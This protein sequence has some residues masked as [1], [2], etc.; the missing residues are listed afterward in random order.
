MPAEFQK[1][2]DLTLSNF[3]NTYAY[4][5]D[6]VIVTKGS[7]DIHKQKH[8]TIL[9]KLDGENLAI[10][11]EK[12]KF[13]CKQVEWLGYI[14]NSEGTTPLI[15]KTEANEKLS[16][17]KLFKQLK[18]FMG[19]I[20]H[21][22]KYIPNSAQAVAALRPLLK[23]TLENSTLNWKLE[24][25]TAFENIKKLVS[26]II[27]NKHFNQHLET[28][29]VTDASTSGLGASLKQYSPK[30]WVANAYASRFLNS[31][32]EKYS[33]NE[34]ESLGVVWAICTENISPSSQTTKL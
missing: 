33:V 17:P 23:N 28:R 29:I 9:E 12:C 13:A 30:S 19:S 25:N 8:Q 4:L 16:P 34:L 1:A 15:R 5:D 11:L 21:L 10:S 24:Q 3:L 7:D 32:D 22:T 26:E 31:L 20:H 27:Q 14:I 2:I 6:I 18:S